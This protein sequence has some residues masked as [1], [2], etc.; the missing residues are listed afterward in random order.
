MTRTDTQL[1]FRIPP[2]LKP[3]L[4]KAA[5][6]N[7]RS[8]NME[9]IE[10]LEQSFKFE[11]E[12]R[13]RIAKAKILSMTPDGMPPLTVGSEVGGDLLEARVAQ[14]ERDMHALLTGSKRKA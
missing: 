2:D 3:R 14:L 6:A 9:V 1:K 10:R 12:A 8:I 7:K 4:E 5:R 13:S 11:T